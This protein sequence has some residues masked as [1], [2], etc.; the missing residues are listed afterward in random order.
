MEIEG[1]KRAFEV[2]KKEGIE[3]NAFISDRHRGIGKWVRENMPEN[4]HFFDVWHVP[5][6]TLQPVYLSMMC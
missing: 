4:H 2:L 6:C 3:I 5:K 1:I